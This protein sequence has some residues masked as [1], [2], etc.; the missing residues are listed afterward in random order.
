MAQQ[1]N[2]ENITI[3]K[4]IHQTFYSRVLP[5]IIQEN[6]SKLKE[7]NSGWEYRFYDE[8]DI[9]EF[10]LNTY[11]VDILN[12]YNKID[13]RYGAARADFFRYLL[14]YK[15]GGVYLDIKSSADMPLDSVLKKED[16]YLLSGWK[17][18]KG[19]E[20]EGIG[21]YP[22]IS[23]IKG[24]EFQQWYIISAPRHPFLTAVIE[25][26]IDNI[27]RYNPV[28]HGTGAMGVLRLTGPLAY[29]L[30]IYPL[31]SKCKHRFLDS[32]DQIGL[33][34]SVYANRF[35]HREV[36]QSHYSQLNEPIVLGTSYQVN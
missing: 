12:Y 20:F 21:I 35:V 24:G 27:Y 18:G 8:N 10:I 3:P 6:I 7:L 1:F 14:I 2:T 15:E 29:S 25:R 28:Q 26:V 4:I 32:S 16:C 9:C 11:G 23:H 5:S 17:N 19:E 13:P 22:E 36:F 33:K 30:A 31:L 34:Y